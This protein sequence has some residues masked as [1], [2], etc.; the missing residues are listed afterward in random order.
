MNLLLH[1]AIALREAQKA[2]MADRGNEELGKRVGVAAKNL[3]YAIERA[4]VDDKNK[5]VNRDKYLSERGY[6]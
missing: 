6:T 1:A 5:I 3:D 2:Y 4:Q